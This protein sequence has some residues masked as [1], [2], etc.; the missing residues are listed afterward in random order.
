[1][2]SLNKNMNILENVGAIMVMV[3]LW[4]A[5]DIIVVAM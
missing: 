3:V 4:I 1:M 5:V 2:L